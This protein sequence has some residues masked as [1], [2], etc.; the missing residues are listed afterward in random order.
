VPLKKPGGAP[1]CWRTVLALRCL[2]SVRLRVNERCCA[3]GLKGVAECRLHPP[4]APW[5]VESKH[6][7]YP[8]ASTSLSKQQ[9]ASRTY[10]CDTSKALAASLVVRIL[11]RI[12]PF[13]KGASQS[14]C[15]YSV[16]YICPVV[17][18]ISLTFPLPTPTP[19]PTQDTKE[20]ALH[21]CT[22]R[23]FKPALLFRRRQT[24]QAR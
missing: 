18:H 13:F 22:S 16:S 6:I 3:A 15:S 21:T 11:E 8:L 23:L 12:G 2:L 20:Q 5:D 1:R 9:Q 4:F 14:R 7:H 24:E 19:S 17:L 10:S